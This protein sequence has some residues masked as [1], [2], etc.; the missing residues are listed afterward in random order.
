MEF[1]V[2]IDIDSVQLI[3]MEQI[4]DVAAIGG[5]C[6]ANVGGTTVGTTM[7]VEADDA[8]GAAQEAEYLVKRI[9][10]AGRVIGCEVLTVEEFDRRNPIPATT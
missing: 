5:P 8:V 2:S 3:T 6:S 4:M 1:T 7:T 9:V 10:G